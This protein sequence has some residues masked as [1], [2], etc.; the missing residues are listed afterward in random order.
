MPAR[1]L[2]GARQPIRLEQP[3]GDGED[4]R[5]GQIGGRIRQYVRRMGDRHP[6]ARRGRE[7]DVVVAD[8]VVGHDLE[9]REPG[10]ERLV[11]R[12][13]Q[14]NPQPPDPRSALRDQ[15]L[16]LLRVS[17]A[18]DVGQ[19][20]ERRQWAVRYRRVDEDE[21]PVAASPGLHGA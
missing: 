9:R 18:R 12:G 15:P 3:A 14:L 6:A 20:V 11:H 8:R 2:P 21:R 10:E 4:Q 1:P 16:Q 7:I 5:P 13:R 19:A 17:E